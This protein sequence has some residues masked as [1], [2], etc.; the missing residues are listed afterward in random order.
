MHKVIHTDTPTAETR[1]FNTFI[2]TSEQYTNS[3]LKEKNAFTREHTTNTAILS[4]VISHINLL[5]E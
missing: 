1:Y 5:A 2:V 3:K 4:A